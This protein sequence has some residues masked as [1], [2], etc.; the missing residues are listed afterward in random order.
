MRI[1][2]KR[3]STED[4]QLPV[5][6]VFACLRPE[7]ADAIWISALISGME[8]EA[9]RE[10]SSTE[11]SCLRERLASTRSGADIAASIAQDDAV[12]AGEGLATTT[13]TIVACVPDLFI[14]TLL[15]GFEIDL[16]DLSEDEASCL[17]G[18][19]ADVDWHEILA[20]NDSVEIFGRTME[21]MAASLTECLPELWDSMWNSDSVDDNFSD[22]ADD[23]ADRPEEATPIAVGEAVAAQLGE[24]PGRPPQT[25]VDGPLG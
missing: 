14:E 17:R 5:D 24:H 2:A 8:N 21:T 12:V 1:P 6:A 10:L 11:R 20:P 23:H 15:S 16:D 3:V 22:M 25:L 18:F 9:N 7:T 19:A 13:A 4:A